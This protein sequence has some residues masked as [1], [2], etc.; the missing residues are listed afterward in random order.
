VRNPPIHTDPCAAATDSPVVVSKDHEHDTN[1]ASRAVD[2]I[3]KGPAFLGKCGELC[4]LPTGLVIGRNLSQQLCF[5]GYPELAE[6]PGQVPF[7]G[8]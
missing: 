6:E 5:G 8:A 7:N 2:R 4:G 3:T 1:D